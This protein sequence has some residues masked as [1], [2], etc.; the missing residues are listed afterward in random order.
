M[1]TTL[2]LITS[3]VLGAL[4]ME[5]RMANY[6]IPELLVI[7]LGL[8]SA[9]TIFYGEHL[10][11]RWSWAMSTGFYALSAANLTFVYFQTNLL[12]LYAVLLVLAFVGIVRSVANLDTE[13]TWMHEYYERSEPLETYSTSAKEQVI[14]PDPV[15][16]NFASDSWRRSTPKASVV[17]STTKAAPKR[18]RSKK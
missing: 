3:Q 15:Y 6:A 8:A 1:L 4:I 18:K 11:E 9:I 12:W 2:G 13:E 17:K 7:V 16:V 14:D 5:T 10:E